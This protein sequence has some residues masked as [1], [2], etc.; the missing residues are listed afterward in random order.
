MVQTALIVGLLGGFIL[1]Y[2][3]GSQKGFARGKQ[4]MIDKKKKYDKGR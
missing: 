1:G 3:L 4:H 2:L